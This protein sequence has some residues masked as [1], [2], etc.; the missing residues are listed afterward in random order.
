MGDPKKTLRDFLVNLKAELRLSNLQLSKRLDIP[1]NIIIAIDGKKLGLDDLTLGIYRELISLKDWDRHYLYEPFIPKSYSKNLV[2][3]FSDFVQKLM[4]EK[5]LSLQDLADLQEGIT[6]EFINQIIHQQVH[7]DQVNILFVKKL[8]IEEGKLTERKINNY[9]YRPI[10]DSIFTSYE[11]DRFA[12]LVY[13]LRERIL[14]I[15]QKDFGEQIG[16]SGSNVSRWETGQ[17]NPDSIKIQHFRT[18]ANLKGWTVEH[19]FT[20]IYGQETQT[21]AYEAIAPK[22][23]SLPPLLRQKL[24]RELLELDKIAFNYHSLEQFSKILKSYI[25]RQNLSLE[26]ASKK[27]RIKPV[28]RLDSLLKQQEL[29]NNMEL[30]RL[31]SLRDFLDEKGD[32]YSYAELKEMIY[33]RFTIKNTIENP[34]QGQ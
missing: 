23:K 29:P 27:L 15:N 13:D 25:K 31:A 20:Y 16:I 2:K 7:P 9:Y 24:V 1:N 26:E 28:S 33:G 5:Q 17:T 3:G 10:L 8:L 6:V 14:Q 22:A 30:L 12:E 21:E 11:V 18:L 19:L 32:R 4:V 34:E